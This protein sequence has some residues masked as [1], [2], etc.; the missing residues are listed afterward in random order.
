MP[1]TLQGLNVRDKE[2]EKVSERE[3]TH[4]FFLLIFT[5]KWLSI[6][7]DE[8]REDDIWDFFLFVSISLCFS[9]CFFFLNCCQSLYEHQDSAAPGEET[10]KAV[11]S[12][13]SPDQV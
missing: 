13:V 5:L 1:D 11:R 12:G 2:K 4:L 10:N 8:N 3:N 6:L 9:C 7:Q